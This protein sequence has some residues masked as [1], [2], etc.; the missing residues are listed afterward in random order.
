MANEIRQDN[1]LIYSWVYRE[2]W[3]DSVGV[4]SRY[5]ASYVYCL[6]D[7]V[8]EVRRA[9]VTTII[10]RQTTPTMNF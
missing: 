6:S 4:W 5:I 1:E 3:G 2:Q 10:P 9:A 8:P 7:F